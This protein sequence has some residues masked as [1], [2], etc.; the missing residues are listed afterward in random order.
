MSQTSYTVTV[1][2]SVPWS[3]LLSVM[4]SVNQIISGNHVTVLGTVTDNILLQSWVLKAGTTTLNIGTTAT[5]NG[6]LISNWNTASFNDGVV[7]LQL[8]VLD[9]AGYSTISTFRVTVDNSAPVISG[10]TINNGDSY[11]AAQRVTL[12][13]AAVDGITPA[14]GLRMLI[15]GNVMTAAGSTNE[16]VAYNSQVVVTLNG[17]T[18]VNTINISV[19]DQVGNLSS[20]FDTITYT[21]INPTVLIS[22]ITPSINGV[23]TASV[24]V[25]GLVTD[26]LGVQ[27]W[28]LSVDG[29]QVIASGITTNLATGI[30]TSNWNTAIETEGVRTLTLIATNLSGLISQTSYTVTLDHTVPNSQIVSVQPSLNHI[31]S[32]NQVTIYG[33]VTDNL[34]VQNWILKAGAT[35]LNTGTVAMVN[36][37]LTS[38]WNTA[39]FNDGVV[40]LQLT[41]VDMAG[42]SSVSLFMITINNQLEPIG[43]VLI[44][45]NAVIYNPI[46]NSIVTGTINIIGTVQAP[47]IN[48]YAVYVSPLNNTNNVTTLGIGYQSVSNNLLATWN[49][50]T[51]SNDAYQITLKILDNQ[52]GVTQSIIVVTVNNLPP[53]PVNS[54]VGV[55]SAGITANILVPTG[56]VDKEV[57]VRVTLSSTIATSNGNGFV[58]ALPVTDNTGQV[59]QSVSFLK[60]IEIQLWPVG[61]DVSFN[62]KVTI[63]TY[64]EIAVDLDPPLSDTTNTRIY[65]NDVASNAWKTDGITIMS[66][67]PTKLI[68][69][70]AHLTYFAIAQISVNNTPNSPTPAIAVFNQF[71]A[72]AADSEVNLT[73]VVSANASASGYN[74]IEIWSS[75]A[76][77]Q[78]TSN[79]PLVP[80]APA[81]LVYAGSIAGPLNNFSFKDNGLTNYRY[82]FYSLWAKNAYG[83]SLTANALAR[84]VPQGRYEAYSFPNPF[85]PVKELAT[86]VFPLSNAGEY[87]LLLFNMLL[88]FFIKESSLNCLINH[89]T[90]YL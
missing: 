82:H 25:T 33:T 72:T 22:N 63:N 88:S 44:S 85:S 71:L 60:S 24:T 78:A 87:R 45:P 13:I 74:T 20:S 64:L 79:Y 57:E 31:I 4:P 42:Y 5:I 6:V 58:I 49:T 83:Y 38:N 15:A 39:S 21:N 8:T 75:S 62:G 11:T 50:R 48:Y 81:V 53:P 2:H 12:D 16:W 51:V 36:G 18:G 52:Q 84:P 65:Y 66:V 10:V 32:G 14:S 17:S 1:D 55:P 86:L 77:S 59:I 67:T 27:S 40:T 46:N 29:G 89:Q 69:R 41:V 26:N 37:V 47:S 23:V 35:T 90:F 34:L 80:T 68:F 76:N 30:L 9:M 56:S 61:N 73:W 28:S 19:K 7:T 70:V 54:I 43:P 3:Q